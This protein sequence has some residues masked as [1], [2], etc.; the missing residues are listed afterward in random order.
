MMYGTPSPRAFAAYAAPEPSPRAR[1][2]YA[3]PRG[4]GSPPQSRH[5]ARDVDP[6]ERD[7]ARGTVTASR[8][9]Q[10]GMW[11]CFFAAVLIV[12]MR[13]SGG[14]FSFI[15]TFGAMARTFGFLVLNLK[16]FAGRHAA[17]VSVKTL[18]LYCLVSAS[19]VASIVQHEGYLPVD[20]SG[21]WLYHWIEYAALVLAGTALYGCTGPFRATYRGDADKIR[22]AYLA[23]PTLV[24]ALLVHPNLTRD[25]VSDVAWTYSMYLEAL[26][27]VPQLYLFQMGTAGVVDR[28]HA[29]FVAALGFGRALEFVFWIFSHKDLAMGSGARLPGYILVGSI[30]LQLLLQADFFYYYYLAVRNATPLVLPKHSGMGMV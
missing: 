15:W 3:A 9:D 17:G 13:V 21:D 29:H 24:L 26:A 14:H 22:A 12:F 5:F 2:E 1:P 18:Q 4:F 8:G 27:L 10:V 19:R 11:A 28:L 30:F 20:K 23:A 25:F 7:A 16:I 6:Y